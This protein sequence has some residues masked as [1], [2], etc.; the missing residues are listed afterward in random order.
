MRSKMLKLK[1]IREMH[2]MDEVSTIDIW[3]AVDKAQLDEYKAE[4][5]KELTLGDVEY[6]ITEYKQNEHGVP[7]LGL[8]AKKT[9]I[10]TTVPLSMVWSGYKNY[11][12]LDNNAREE[13]R[14]KY[15]L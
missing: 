13:L 3:E 1:H 4:G 14:R 6:R 9:R 15:F 7:I 8:V 12:A 11:S 10:V 2:E 5:H